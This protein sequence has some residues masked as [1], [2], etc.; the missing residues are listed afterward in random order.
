MLTP[1]L[2]PGTARNPSTVNLVVAPA[3]APLDVTPQVFQTARQIVFTIP[4]TDTTNDPTAVTEAVGSL[5]IVGGQPVMV[6]GQGLSATPAIDVF[7][8]TVDG[9][10]SWKIIGWVTGVDLPSDLV[11]LP[12]ATY[13]IGPPPPPP[14]STPPPGVYLL[15]GRQIDAIEKDVLRL[16]HHKIAA[17]APKQGQEGLVA[18]QRAAR[19]ISDLRS[20]CAHKWLQLREKCPF[21]AT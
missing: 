2:G 5:S 8:A 14:A 4:P 21:A 3:A 16:P 10:T 20:D 9:T 13:A 11:M 18:D 7:L 6:G 1:S 12:P 19:R 17:C 15:S